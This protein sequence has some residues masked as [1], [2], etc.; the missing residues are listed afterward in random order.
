MASQQLQSAGRF[1]RGRLIFVAILLII[2]VVIPA[3]LHHMRM[4]IFSTDGQTLFT[5]IG[6][7]IA[8]LPLVFDDIFSFILAIPHEISR[9]HHRHQILISYVIDD[10]KWA[11]WMRF[12]LKQAGY[13][14]TMRLWDYQQSGHKIMKEMRESSKDA[15][16]VISTISPEYLASIGIGTKQYHK[17][18]RSLK[19]QHKRILIKVRRFELDGRLKS[20]SKADLM[21]SG[22]NEARA[23]DLLRDSLPGTLRKRWVDAVPLTAT[24]NDEARFPGN[25]PEHWSIRR[26]TTFFT[27]REDIL[28][29]LFTTF[30]NAKPQPDVAPQA[31]VGL[32]GVGTS[33]IAIEYANHY[34]SE[35]EAGFC[36]RMSPDKAREEDMRQVGN[37]LNLTESQ[38]DLKK[39]RE[40]IIDWLNKHQ[41]WLLILDQCDDFTLI[42]DFLPAP[43]SSNG[44]ILLTTQI[45]SLGADIN[46]IAVKELKTAEGALFLLRRTCCLL[47]DSPLENAP[48]EEREAALDISAKVGGMPSVLN[49]IGD[50]LHG[51]RL[52]EVCTNYEMLKNDFIAEQSCTWK[53]SYEKV[54]RENPVAA[55]VLAFCALLGQ[56]AIPL[57]LIQ[58]VPD[59]SLSNE[60]QLLKA[61]NELMRYSLIS[62]NND[63]MVVV[64]FI[65]QDVL[66]EEMDAD[67]KRVWEK[68]LV[69]AVSGAFPQTVEVANLQEAKIYIPHVRMCMEI[70]KRYQMRSPE[71]ADMFANAAQCQNLALEI[72]ESEQ[73]STYAL[74]LRGVAL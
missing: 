19:Q 41:R 46:T 25:F 30:Q 32:G 57:T 42:K 47:P 18:K 24:P 71:I 14:V 44:N 52:P 22:I 4:G 69:H 15:K 64:P 61:I 59:L 67:V 36:I 29:E 2:F 33:A 9:W 35:Y 50:S 63:G 1:S 54:Q 38:G 72:A 13:D 48:Q 39:L 51:M 37:R 12:Q 23:K 62:R 70:T 28:K 6:V 65:V 34:H 3:L 45:Q 74:D 53:A 20:F 55:Q 60:G 43:G 66:R 16:C 58:K 31:L 49:T 8:I 7:V 17:F 10:Y 27:S 5:V 26:S 73:F 11:K 40:Q 68:Q 56:G 21:G